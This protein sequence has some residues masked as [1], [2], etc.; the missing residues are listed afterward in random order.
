MND[1][2]ICPHCGSKML[3]WKVPEFTTWGS[4]YFFVCFN[5]ECPYFEKGWK[6]MDACYAQECSYRHR[7]DPET[8]HQGPLP[9]ISKEHLRECIIED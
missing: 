8:G 3:K 5:D 4:E 6:H 7:F 9:V 2:T 1:P